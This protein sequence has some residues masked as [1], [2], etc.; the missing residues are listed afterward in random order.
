MERGY[1]EKN[2]KIR[3]GRKKSS[4]KMENRNRKIIVKNN[5]E[6]KIIETDQ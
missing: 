1:L 4:E 2:M 5:N 3:E 6:T